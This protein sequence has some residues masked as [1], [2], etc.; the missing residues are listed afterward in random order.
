MVEP[1]WRKSSYS[2]ANGQCVEVAVT[3]SRVVTRDTKQGGA[4]PVLAVPA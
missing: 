1:R 2:E 3:G 4:G